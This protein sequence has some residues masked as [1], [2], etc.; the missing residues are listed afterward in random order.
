MATGGRN[1]GWK[2]QLGALIGLYL[3]NSTAN[4]SPVQRKVGDIVWGSCAD[5]STLPGAECGYAIVPLDYFNST[6]GVAKIALGRY[7]A[8]TSPRKGSVFV[9]PGGPGGT[10]VSLA[11]GSGSFLQQVIGEEYDIIGFDPRGIGQT[12]PATRCFPS[13]E[14]RTAFIANTVLD[15]GY[16]VSPNLTDPANRYHLIQT[17]RDAD[18]LYKTQFAICG[19]TM[20][21]QLRYMG[22]STVSRDID[23][24]TTLLDGKDA[25]INF[26]G[27]SYGTVIGQYLANMYAA[28]LF[29]ERIG[30]VA[31]DGVVDADAWANKPAYTWYRTWLSSTEG[32]YK[33]F[34]E[35][36]AKAGPSECALAKS[37]NDSATD[38]YN[39]V[40]DFV[41]KLYDEPLPAPNAT[42]PG[43]L[44]NGRARLPQNWQSTAQA[45]AAAMAGDASAVLDAVNEKE[46]V[47]MERSAVSCNDNKPFAPPKPEDVIDEALFVQQNVTRFGLTITISEPDSGCQ[48]WPVTPPERFL[49]PWNSTTKNPI[50]IISNTNDPATPISSGEIV[51]KALGNSSALLVLDAPGHTSLALPSTCIA[52]NAR[53]FFANGT[54]PVEGTVCQP[55]S[56]PFPEAETANITGL[57]AIGSSKALVSSDDKLLASLRHISSHIFKFGA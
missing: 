35:D 4:V 21:D 10:G 38:I 5:N 56:G 3:Q 50:L 6:A 29:P 20:G 54:L 45:F 36:C 44:T 1:T 43:I 51:H 53:A 47:D 33:L 34:F 19:Q 15:R 26:Y 27:L 7:N 42:I 48:F 2:H 28:G 18:A 55:N 52:L 23:F 32:A 49:G 11:T 14:A 46:L 8:T 9:N 24:M 37:R 12:E 41:N 25:L 31:I 22:T 13:P 16:D 57:A 17:Q 40:E 30:R 39:R